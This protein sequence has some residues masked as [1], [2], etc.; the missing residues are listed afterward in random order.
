MDILKHVALALEEAARQGVVHGWLRPESV[1]ISASGQALVDDLCAAKPISFLLEQPA[2]PSEA[3]EHWLAPECADGREPDLRSDIFCLGALLYRMITG[4]GLVTGAACRQALLRYRTGEPPSLRRGAQSLSPE[5]D[6]FFRRLVAADPAE[7]PGSWSEVIQHIDRFGGSTAR[8][9][10]RF[11]KSQYRGH[12]PR[13]KNA[14][15]VS[16]RR[17]GTTGPLPLPVEQPPSMS[18]A[19]ISARLP[20]M[21]PVPAPL[22]KSSSGSNLMTGVLLGMF[23]VA[24][25]AS[26]YVISTHKIATVPTTI[27]PESLPTA[28]PTTIAT[29][30]AATPKPITP[31]T[32]VERVRLIN[33]VDGMILAERYQAALT[34]L[35]VLPIADRPVLASRIHSAHDTRQKEVEAAVM[36]ARTRADAEAALRPALLTWG[37]PGDKA[38]AEGLLATAHTRIGTVATAP[39][40]T[41]TPTPILAPTPTPVIVSAPT[42]PVAAAPPAP[43]VAD[44]SV[45]ALPAN[46]WRI[47]DRVDPQLD[48][49]LL[50]GGAVPALEVTDPAL[51]RA[52]ASKVAL[53]NFRNLLLNQAVAAKIRLRLPHPTT[54]EASDITKADA[55][56]LDLSAANGSTSAVTWNAIPAAELSSLNICRQG[57]I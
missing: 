18:G 11:T 54:G 10:A 46:P 55:K 36:A 42:A 14:S 25:V 2:G 56:G 13:G 17:R 48:R 34:Q 8:D 30:Q 32:P 39:T 57:S 49:A 21:A 6:A 27:P 41:P 52:L 50:L 24:I 23:A 3:T 26:A 37:L 53:W 43:T 19:A 38:W 35:D 16:R 44:V 40:P 47:Y 9:S 7:R 45:P 4:A 51:L 33:E 12:T 15:T 1:L 20:P 28:K 31:I 22:P 5:L 29:V